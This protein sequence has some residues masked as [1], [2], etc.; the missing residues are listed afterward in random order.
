MSA[1]TT[2]HDPI[3]P[4]ELL[5]A[6][7]EEIARLPE[8]LR[9]AVVLCDLQG[10]P[11]QQAAE[12]LRLSERTLRRR[13][14][15]GRE[16]L[17]ARLD[18]RGLAWGEAVM[19]AVRLRE[20]GTVIP[21]TWREAAIRAA[22]DLLNPTVAAGAVSAAAQSLTDEVLKTMFVQKL[23]MASAVL[24]GAG[25][26]AWAAAAVL[27]TQGDGP[28]KAATA[29]VDQRAA[30][31]RRPDAQ[32]DLLDETGTLP[33]RGRV[34]DPDGRPVAGAA[35]HV[36]RQYSEDAW[37]STDPV[38]HGQRGRVA[39]SVPDGRF[40]FEL[41]TSPSDFPYSDDP[42]WHQAKIAAI[43]P[44]YGPAW[45][46]AGS[47]KGGEATLQLVRDDVPIRGRVVD[48]QGRPVAG[49][50]VRAYR[51]DAVNAEIDHD[52]L[53]AAGEF[54]YDRA[55]SHYMNPTWLGRQGTWTTDADGRFE[56]TGVGR[57]RVIGL[58]LD[59][60]GLAHLNICV[61]ARPSRT[62]PRLRPRPSGKPSEM[63]FFDQPLFPPLYGATFELII[64]P[65]KPI[66]GVVRIKGTGR[67]AAGITVRGIEPTTG[68][69]IYA[70]AEQGGRFRILGLP[71]A[72]VYQ[73]RTEARSGVEPYLNAPPLTVGDTE[74]LKPIETT[75]DVPRGVI[76]TG[77]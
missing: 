65:S 38:T 19:A 2:S 48:P 76:I 43:A 33:I 73:L 20:A 5:P 45:I 42:V 15:D 67:P 71:K 23:A 12:S 62:P 66:I 75:I 17:K 77:A 44:G 40:Q 50:T 51:I 24:L 35:I 49:V 25:L 7:H 30:P 64:G 58:G 56:V 1:M 39:M 53:I 3:I 41:D 16:R 6:L 69:W 32:A 28:P 61:M 4:D 27:T 72:G 52:S 74:G 46:A 10:I 29:P 9:L 63:M 59:G 34:L 68:T 54:P 18:R 22:L 11:Q 60:P 31:I 14:A 8:R 13:L 21:P 70:R 55:T 37:H 36:W 26:M 47:L 57:N